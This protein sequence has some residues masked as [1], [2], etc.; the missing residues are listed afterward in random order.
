LVASNK[1]LTIHANYCC[2][3]STKTPTIAQRTQTIKGTVYVYEDYPYWDS[4]KKQTRHKRVYIG[5]KDDNGTFIPNKKYLARTQPSALS[6]PGV[7]DKLVKRRF[8]GVSF[9]LDQIAS[10]TMIAEDLRAF[11]P[12]DYRII[13]S[14]AYYLVSESDAPMYRFNHWARTHSHPYGQEL[15]SQRISE[16]FARI[17]YDGIMRFLARQRKRYQDSEHLVYDIT[18][19]SSYSELLRQVRYGNNKSGE[20][21]PQLNLALV[22]GQSSMMPVYYRTLPGNVTDVTTLRKL[23]RDLQ[24]MDMGKVKLVLDRGFYS[25]R[26]IDA[27]YKHRCK[28]VVGARKN[29]RF[30]KGHLADNRQTLTD[31]TSY[32]AD[33]GIAL[34]QCYGQLGI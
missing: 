30:I 34:F 3:Y 14:L 22:F 2:N 5:K 32:D 28:F 20:P 17:N 4:E 31:F 12:K 7:L 23:L 19:I 15:S 8:G 18:S 33:L 10:R 21:L 16:V 1:I 29:T 9:L 24:D 13:Q 25:A 27:L 6:E 11:F 26:N